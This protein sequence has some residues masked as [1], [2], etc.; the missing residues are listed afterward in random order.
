MEEQNKPTKK[1]SKGLKIYLNIYSLF[2]Y[3]TSMFYVGNFIGNISFS[4]ELLSNIVTYGF[5]VV[6]TASYIVFLIHG[7]KALNQD[8]W[9]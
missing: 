5:F 6:H 2:L 4:S 7:K 1:M 9:Q 3:L 8:T